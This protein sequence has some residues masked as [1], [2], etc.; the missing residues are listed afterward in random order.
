MKN[1]TNCYWWTDATGCRNTNWTTGS[2]TDPDVPVCGL[3]TPN[4]KSPTSWRPKTQARVL[5]PRIVQCLQEMS[6]A[7]STIILH[8]IIAKALRDFCVVHPD[9]PET[10]T[11]QEQQALEACYDNNSIDLYHL[12]AKIMFGEP[13]EDIK[14]WLIKKFDLKELLMHNPCDNDL[15]FIIKMFGRV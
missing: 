3:L 4:A 1:C 9:T 14:D 13:T 10:L 12:Y 15:D 6:E 2:R 5:H 8:D 7:K 11:E